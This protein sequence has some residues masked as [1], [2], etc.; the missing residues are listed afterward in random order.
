MEQ[1]LLA[2][3][4]IILGLSA[5]ILFLC[6]RLRLPAIVGFLLAG[7]LAGPHGL[8]LV[9]AVQ[10]VEAIAEIGIVLLLFTIGIEFSLETLARL[11]RAVLLG[12]TLQVGTTLIAVTAVLLGAGIAAPAAVL[13]GMLATLSSTAIVLKIMH[14]RAEIDALHGRFTVGILIFQDLV[15]VPMLLAVPLLAGRAAFDISAVLPFL[16]KTFLVLGFILIAA[17]W[18]LPQ[19]LH[20]IARTRDPELFQAAVVVLGLGIAYLTYVAGLSLA[21]GAFL[22]GLILSE[23]PYAQRA[24]GSLLP[25]R[26][27]FMSF[28][29]VS[30]GM[31]FDLRIL[32]SSPAIVIGGAASLIV[33]K[34]ALALVACIAAGL[35][36]RSS[37]LAGLALAQVGEF[38][39][40]LARS[41]LGHGLLNEAQFQLFLG[42]SALSMIA[43]PFLI[44]AA[45][46]VAEWAGRLPLPGRLRVGAFASEERP[47]MRD[48]LVI[49]GFG[50]IGRHVAQAAQAC[51]I[52]YVVLEANPDTVHRERA[53]GQ[54]IFHC[55]ATQEAALHHAGAGEARAAVVAVADITGTRRIVDRLRALSPTLHI[56]ART[57]YF[58]ETEPLLGLG[59][60]EVICEEYETSIEIFTRVL[61]K[62]LVPKEQIGEFVERVRSSGYA[63]LRQPSRAP[64]LLADLDLFLSNMEV[65]IVSAE[66]GAGAIGRSLAQ[67]DLRRAYGIMVLAIRRD[68]STIQLPDG[69]ERFR[70]GD[71]VVLLGFPELLPFAVTIFRA[72]GSS[73]G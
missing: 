73:T 67:I 45:P 37:I 22:A 48:H 49:I 47:S 66:A 32:A 35:P 46:R 23:S 18:I 28:F 24:L 39:F 64:R 26:D 21:M 42:A 30:V 53:L 20:Q 1:S 5:F 9:S 15:V 65:R 17:K 72:P 11:R 33:I 60:N 58:V 29:F 31:L 13:G 8:S 6:Q 2:D 59:A 63:M 57:R 52:G 54:P 36:L 34:G 7:V 41:A 61:Q 70:A 14:E 25:L 19:T 51:K 3:I 50:L 69:D 43:A 56:I 12:G 71:E 38:S 27:L 40:I 16:A 44:D 4:I 62:Y 68:G 10:E 55:D